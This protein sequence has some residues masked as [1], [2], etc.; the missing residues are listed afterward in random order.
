MTLL[1][2]CSVVNE[3]PRCSTVEAK[4]REAASNDTQENAQCVQ[5]PAKGFL[6]EAFF[7]VS[8]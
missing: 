2:I 6:Y 4:V 3:K 1:G 7:F 5:V 8:L